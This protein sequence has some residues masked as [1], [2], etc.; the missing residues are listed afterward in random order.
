MK[1][2]KIDWCDCTL[3]PVKGC[4]NG[5]K[6]CYARKLNDRF[7]FVKD[8]NKL[9]FFPEVLEQ[10]KSKKPKSIFMDSMSDCGHWTIS[11]IKQIAK[12][13]KNNPQ[14]N[15]IFLTKVPELFTSKCKTIVEDANNRNVFVGTTITRR[16]E[17]S[18]VYDLPAFAYKFV[19]IEPIL[20]DFGDISNTDLC[21][22]CF[23]GTI[24]I[25]A[26]TGNRK[27][28]VVPKKEWI[29]NIVKS[30]DKVNKDNEDIIK[31]HKN[32]D[33]LR[34]R[35]FM[36]ESLRNIMGDDFRQDKLIWDVNK[37]K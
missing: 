33:L 17:I 21:S 1:N 10:L 12:A 9:E 23:N 13:M 5:C 34:I 24:I 22:R 28:K 7:N 32:G 2:T 19:S 14:H 3:N 37:E 11:Q 18:R 6:Y 29:M 30:V 8:W 20:E 4:P 16:N 25:G 31:Y 26:E 35:I 27:D 36:K 15:Y